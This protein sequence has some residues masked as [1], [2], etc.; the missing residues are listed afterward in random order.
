MVLWA[1]RAETFLCLFLLVTLSSSPVKAAKA[2]LA[3]E[4]YDKMR[5][6]WL[7]QLIGNS[8]GQATEGSYSGPEPNPDSAVPWVIKQQW[9]GDDD[10]DI[11]YVALHI[12]ETDG[13]NCRRQ[14]MAE[15]WFTHTGSSGIYIAN[16]QAWHLMKDGY[17]PPETGSRSYNEHWYSI[18][19]QIGTEI[20]GAISPGSIQSAIDLAAQ[21]A[22]LTN[23]GFPV[24]AAQFYCAMYA[25]AFFEPN[26]V[27]IVVEGLTVVP[28]TSRTYQ[29]VADVLTWYLDDAQDGQFDWRST[30]R[31]LYDNYQGHNSLGRYYNWVESTINTGATVLAI[32]Y[33][34]G[35]FSDTVQIA[36]LA[37]WD[38]DC[39]PATAGGLIGII[40]GFSNLPPDL[41]D[42]NICGD[43]YKNVHRPYLPDP[44]Q[45]L[46]QYDTITSIAGRLTNLAER[47]ILGNG[48]YITGSG[49]TKTYHIPD[50]N[51]VSS[52]PDRPDP[53]GPTG[54]VAEALAAGIAVFPT[55]AI[56]RYDARY[57]RHNLDA[58]ID[59]ITDN[60]H[61]GHKAY[62]SRV[63]YARDHDWY[64]LNFSEQVEFESL[65]FWEGDVV[66]NRINSY[67]KED[68]PEGGFFED[69]TVE[70]IKDGT[71]IVPH[72]LESF[73]E[74][75][76]FEMY[77]KITFTFAPTIGEAIRIT[78][79]PGGTLGYTTIMELE[80]A[81]TLRPNAEDTVNLD[82]LH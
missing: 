78:G 66:W 3:D 9:D 37:G 60:S 77:Q 57:D 46:P 58:I 72:N 22:G 18:D 4:L 12:L 73:P 81:G 11:E 65:T 10:T 79:T 23:T 15:E 64:Q 54:L 49:P 6:M 63:D 16:K 44:N 32:L 68:D 2:I 56:A 51:A 76:P 36:V 7:G 52:E 24:H 82:L 28:T 38:C 80:V 39:N 35:D 47:S 45:P 20:L 50:F 48:G 19:S 1:A 71:P 25:T 69:L 17:L 21:F 8:T 29:V 70:V 40:E 33:G 62:Y 75:D 5:G 74:L 13:L 31:K 43:I 42:P 61:N 27:D 53:N 55:A 59:G 67:Y 14:K 26:V 41:T 34:R 30:R